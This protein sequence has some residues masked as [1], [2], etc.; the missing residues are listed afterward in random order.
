MSLRTPVGS[1]LLL[2]GTGPGD[3]GIRAE[4]VVHEGS[5]PLA[6]CPGEFDDVPDG[7]I[8]KVV[9]YI[10]HE[11]SIESCVDCKLLLAQSELFPVFS[12]PC[13]ELSFGHFLIPLIPFF[14][15]ASI[16]SADV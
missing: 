16:L 14:G 3:D 12:D 13:S 6:E 11:S 5:D 8:H 4:L 10:R 2:D 7:G 9:L 15:T 1:G